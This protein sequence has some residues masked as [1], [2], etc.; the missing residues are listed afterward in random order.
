MEYGNADPQNR[1]HSECRPG[2]WRW[3]HDDHPQLEAREIECDYGV[4]Y[5]IATRSL[6][7][8]AAHETLSYWT[9]SYTL[10]SNILYHIL[11]KVFFWKCIVQAPLLVMK[12]IYRT[13]HRAHTHATHIQR[14]VE[15]MCT[16]RYCSR[17][18]FLFL[19]L[20]C[21]ILF[22]LQL[23]SI[24]GLIDTISCCTHCC[25]E[26]QSNSQSRWATFAQLARKIVQFALC[27]CVC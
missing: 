1:Y 17:V 5:A 27:H 16:C 25:Q 21:W 26:L 9:P 4:C 15:V 10:L 24:Q 12:W 6:I 8:P 7:S 23:T 18:F 20:Y 11:Y 22:K 3:W 2:G 14:E 19:P 13:P